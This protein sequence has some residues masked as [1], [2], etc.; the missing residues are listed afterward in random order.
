M[1]TEARKRERE[2]S[3]GE[4]EQESTSWKGSSGTENP[5]MEVTSRPSERLGGD[6]RVMDSEMKSGKME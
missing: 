4:K 1:G 6:P 2:I 5:E 3:N